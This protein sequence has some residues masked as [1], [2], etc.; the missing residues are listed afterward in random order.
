M[1]MY[2]FGTENFVFQIETFTP[3]FVYSLSVSFMREVVVEI[4]P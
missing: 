3:Q 1:F 4:L 2:L